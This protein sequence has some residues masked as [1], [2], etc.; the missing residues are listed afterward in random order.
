MTMPAMAPPDR[1]E[2]DDD[3]DD[4]DDDDDDAAAPPPP[5]AVAEAPEDE[6]VAVAMAAPRMKPSMGWAK[7]WSVDLGVKGMVADSDVEAYFATVIVSP[8]VKSE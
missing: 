5:D 3:G 2:S 6:P 4:D 8:T 1:P 7:A